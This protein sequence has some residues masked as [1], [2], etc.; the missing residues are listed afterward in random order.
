V[1]IQEIFEYLKDQLHCR[2][3]A[4][5]AKKLNVQPATLSGWKTRNAIGTLLGELASKQIPVS[6]DQILHQN[7]NGS[8]RNQTFVSG[9][10]TQ[11]QETQS[12]LDRQFD[13][14][15]RLIAGSAEKHDELLRW[16]KEFNKR[17]I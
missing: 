12:E 8:I 14:A 16:L 10:I 13:V 4:E 6:I 7:I 11:Q 17:M 15:K 1:E 5:L 9:K 2:T 3:D